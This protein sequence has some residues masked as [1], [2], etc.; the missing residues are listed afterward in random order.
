[1]LR[2][3]AVSLTVLLTALCTMLPSTGLRAAPGRKAVLPPGVK[4]I[5]SIEG[6]TEYR[7]AN[8]LKVLIFPDRSQPRVTVNI[9][10]FVGSRHEGYG[11]AGMAHLLEHMLFKG[12][13]TH[14]NIPKSLKDR[15]AVMNGSTWVDRT[16]YF[17]TLPATGDN[18]EFAIRLEAD[19]MVNSSVKAADLASEMTVVRNEFER[20]ENSPTSILYQR[21]LAAAYEWHNYG[22]STIG[23]RADIERVP[24]E[25]L[26]VFYHRYYQPDNAM[27]VVAGRFDPSK[28][29]GLVHKYFGAIPRPKR[30]LRNTYTEEPAQDG[31]RSVT[32]RRVGKVAAVGV[33]YHIP[34]G[35]DPDYVALDVLEGVLTS[36]PSGRLYKALVETKQATSVSGVAFGWH[37]PGVLLLL[38]QVAAGKQPDDVLHALLDT[39]ETLKRKGATE[40]EVDRIKRRLLKQRELAAANSSRLA[41]RLS[42]W[43]AQGDWRLYFIYRDRLE[44]VTPADVNRVARKYLVRNNRTVGRFLPTGKPERASIPQPPNLAAMIG[45]YRGRKAVATGEVFDPKPLNIEARTRRTTLPSGIK[46]ALLTKKTRGGMVYLRLTLRYG[47]PQSLHGLATAADILP[48]MLLRGTKKLSRQQLQDKIDRQKARLSLSGSAGSVTV[49]IQTKRDNLPA[50]LDLLRQVLREP[51]FPNQEL[52]IIKRQQLAGI[53]KQLTN[54]QS[55]ASNAVRRELNRYP[56]G[57]PRYAATLPEQQVMVQSLTRD[58]LLRLY[59]ENLSGRH[60]QL[61]IVGDFDPAA[62]VPVINGILAGWEP[63]QPY[64]RLKRRNFKPHPGLRRIPTPG[65][66]N[67]TLFGATAFPLRDDNPDYPA[68]AIGN[69]ILGGSGLSSRLADRVRQKEGYSYSVGSG[70]QSMSLDKRTVFYIYAISNPANTDKAL[71]A[72][73]EEL[74]RFIKDGITEKELRSAQRG[75]LQRQ[76]INR[77]NDARLVGLLAATLHADRTMKYTASLEQEI[78]SLTPET[79]AGA[80][81]RHI[82]PKTL[83]IVL[84]G[85]FTAKPA[86]TGK[87]KPGTTK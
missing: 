10:Y 73:R 74:A 85:D 58:D 5:R 29:L 9:T 44:K 33:A 6:I 45:D 26:R 60:G 42:E 61:A 37:D 52:E 30:K 53:S 59:R 55:L 67:A 3:T 71:G 83:F 40:N 87:K 14:P 39:I 2:R 11:E 19:R 49:S 34:A 64:A 24:V 13:P 68:L 23:N 1:M 4:K 75:Y 69:F 56:K 16:N 46:A 18:L 15:G 22:K 82:D 20:G 28:A 27:L 54:P 25:S 38:A 7:L 12:T 51:V 57:D 78:R 66:A 50:V 35:A 48:T 72:I 70:L 76:E 8:G 63:R 65:K 17:E 43:A 84:A 36:A 41:I 31:E 80:V 79:V 86:A 62:T 47:N 32:L 21:M 77:A 81:R